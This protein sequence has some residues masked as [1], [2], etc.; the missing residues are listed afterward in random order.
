MISAA[1]DWAPQVTGGFS[2]FEN[3]ALWFVGIS[4]PDGRGQ[5]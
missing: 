3:S 2:F 5:S 1:D 4:L